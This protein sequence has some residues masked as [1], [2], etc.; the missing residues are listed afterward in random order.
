MLDIQYIRDHA[1]QARQATLDKGFDG[2]AVDKLLAVDR[3]VLSLPEFNAVILAD[4]HSLPEYLANGSRY[5][6]VM[7]AVHG[8]KAPAG[9]QGPAIRD[10]LFGEQ[11]RALRMAMP[12]KD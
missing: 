6:A 1:D 10:W 4:H 3:S 2:S 7:K 11:V 9:L 8:D 12:A 5:L